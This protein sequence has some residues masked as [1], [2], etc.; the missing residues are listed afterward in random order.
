LNFLRKI[1]GKTNESLM[2]LSSI[3][4]FYCSLQCLM[5]I[6]EQCTNRQTKLNRATHVS[7][8]GCDNIKIGHC[9]QLLPLN[10]KQTTHFDTTT[11]LFRFIAGLWMPTSAP[12]SHS[13]PDSH[14]N[15]PDSLTQN[16]I[17]SHPQY[18]YH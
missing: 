11:T 6:A 1:D 5:E 2:C 15:N 17:K 18:H 12:S 13:P 16:A 4:N 10:H 3:R 7:D 14:L 9:M 8:R